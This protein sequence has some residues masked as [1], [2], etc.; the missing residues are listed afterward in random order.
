MCE[1]ITMASTAS[2]FEKSSLCQNSSER[3]FNTNLSS[4]TPNDFVL[5]TNPVRVMQDEVIRIAGG[6]GAGKTFAQLK[7]LE[8]IINHN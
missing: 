5:N 7:N 8:E 2:I 6:V 4:V 1:R 3:I